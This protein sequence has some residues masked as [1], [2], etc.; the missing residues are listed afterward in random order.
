MAVNHLIDNGHRQ[1]AFI[2]GPILPGPRPIDTIYTFERRGAGYRTALLDAGIPVNYAL[3]DNDSSGIDGG[4]QA[5]Q[6]LIERRAPFTALFC[7]NDEIAIGAMKALRLA[8][9]RLPEDVSVLGFD[10]IALVEHLTPALTTIRVKKEAMGSIAVK[11]L[12]EL[13]NDPFDT[14]I[15]SILE[16]ELIER[17]SVHCLLH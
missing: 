2:G 6:R 14:N 3:I 1:I 5:C 10:D 4:Y 7:A 9:Y 17:D 13:G 12:L 16:V 8:G 15:S 11:R